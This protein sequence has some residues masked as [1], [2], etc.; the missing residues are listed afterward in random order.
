M[1]RVVHAVRIQGENPVS[2]SYLPFIVRHNLLHRINVVALVMKQGS[3]LKHEFYV[4][5]TVGDTNMGN[6]RVT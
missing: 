3:N 4:T 5:S 6:E 1:V 2:V